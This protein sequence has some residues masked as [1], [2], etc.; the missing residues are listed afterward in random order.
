MFN[1]RMCY[2][3]ATI[4]GIHALIKPKCNQRPIR[5]HLLNTEA[6]ISRSYFFDLQ[7]TRLNH[8]TIL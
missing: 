5:I 4:I 7:F 1:R 8:K 3:L 2:V 6:L